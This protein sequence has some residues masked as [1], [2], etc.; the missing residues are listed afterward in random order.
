MTKVLF[1][2]LLI[3][4]ANQ[5]YPPKFYEIPEIS[6]NE[7]TL[8]VRGVFHTG[9]T[10]CFFRPD[11]TR[12][13]FKDSWFKVTEI[14]NGKVGHKYIRV[15]TAMLPASALLDKLEEDREYLVL[16]RPHEHSARLIASA[17]GLSF[18]EALRDTEIIAIVKLE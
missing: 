7:A 3:V 6:R 5:T 4:S 17:D 16:L 18:Q 11:G 14:Y 8:I 1:S 15:N 2:L 13:W 12:V 9:R 10:P